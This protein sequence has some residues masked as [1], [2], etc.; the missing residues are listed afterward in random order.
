MSL[1]NLSAKNKIPKFLK[2]NLNNKKINSI[3]KKF[4]KSLTIKENLIVAVSGGPDSLAL[5]FLAKIYSIKNK[6]NIKFFIV[7]H[8]LRPES[9]K[10]AKTIK[11]LLKKYSIYLEI[12]TWQGKKPKKNI[13]SIARK[14]RY[15]LLLE[16]CNKL[17][18]NNILFAHHQD[19]L[20]ENFFIRIVRGSGLKGLISL[21]KK[22]SYKNVNFL[23]PLIDQKK[24]DLLFL[25]K[26]VFNFYVTDPS[27]SDEKFKRIQIRN[28]MKELQK[29]GLDKN[30]FLITIKNLKL[31][32]DVINFY[33][34]KN[35][36]NNTFFL[37][38]KNK[39]ILN[40]NFFDQPY[41]VIFRSL[42]DSI[43]TI[44][45]KYYPVRGK[46]LDKIIKEIQNKLVAKVTLG[47]C[48]IEKVNQ[49]VIIS[50]EK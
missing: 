42:S 39:L 2:K 20:F 10:E 27:N 36:K 35:L 4:E 6:L 32:N 26:N 43:K 19:D 23:R 1:K 16:K 12:L 41:E 37:S 50:K 11:S 22:T 31:S 38:K 40:S 21:D 48:I 17:K 49:T 18:I 9:T 14:K 30:K 15:E 13:Q 45:D 47:G 46:K 44:G 3:Y 34:N 29:F 5:A 25:S 8:K 24:E 28:S 33:V 7:D